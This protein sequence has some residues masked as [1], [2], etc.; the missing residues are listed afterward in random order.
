M[1]KFTKVKILWNNLFRF[2]EPEKV[3]GAVF[4]SSFI[5]FFA[6]AFGYLKNFVIAILLG[7]SYQT[8]GFFMAIS[9]I[10]IFLIFVDV[11]DSIGVPNLV[12]A[13]L[14]SQ[15]DFNR[16][17]GLLFTFTTILAFLGSI[18]AFTFIPLILK[19]PIGFKENAISKIISSDRKRPTQKRDRR[20]NGTNKIY[21]WNQYLNNIGVDSVLVDLTEDQ[22]YIFS[23]DTAL[24]DSIMD[25]HEFYVDENDFSNFQG[26]A[27]G[28]SNDS[29]V[30]VTDKGN[31]R[32]LQLK[33]TVNGVVKLSNGYLHPTF[34]GVYDKDIATYGSGAGTV[35]NPRGISADDDGNIYFTQIGGN[36]LV[37]KLKKQGSNYI[38]E[39]TLFED[40]IMDLNRFNRPFDITTDKD[41]AIFVID[42]EDGKVYK[43]FNKGASAGEVA[44]LGK[45]GL[46]EAIFN[47]PFSIAISDE[48]IVYIA[49][50]GNHRIE[51][52]Q[53]SVSEEDLPVEQPN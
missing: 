5:N 32:I 11:F 25:I 45:K 51:R 8:D 4:K 26:I 20:I 27:F 13:K 34:Q 29:T 21:V 7:F 10:G 31:N 48:D 40:A 46:A 28:P 18:L 41:D 44:S 19:I 1:I 35:D 38:S 2:S 50:T 9:L 17:S 52:F 12:K 53:L 23:G 42:N 36:F 14:R 49:D 15:E 30:F 22:K 47:S 16:L 43:F 24:I 3:L 6:R 33:I 37:Q 39:Y